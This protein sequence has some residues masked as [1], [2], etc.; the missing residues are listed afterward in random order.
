ML[1][2]ES[3]RRND[4]DWVGLGDVF[5]FF[6]QQTAYDVRLSLVGSEMCIRDKNLSFLLSNIT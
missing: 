4:N 3:G 6:K 2:V 1:E 5:F